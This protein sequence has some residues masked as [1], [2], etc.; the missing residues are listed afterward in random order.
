MEKNNE[1]AVIKR[2]NSLPLV[3]RTAEHFI[4]PFADVIETADAFV[5]TIDMPGVAKGSISVT[6]EK[7]ALAVKGSVEAYHD[8]QATLLVRELENASY[9]RVFNL[10]D[11][12]DR[13]NVDAKFEDGVLTIKLFKT[14]R[15]KPREIQIK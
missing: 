11:G 5:L 10:G 7:K 14:E 13:D 9:Y 6:L 4:A 8:E 1:V 2:D 12:I 3:S 15:V